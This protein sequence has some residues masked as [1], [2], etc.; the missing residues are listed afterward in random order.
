MLVYSERN[1]I[2]RKWH[3]FQYEFED[4]GAHLGFTQIF[5]PALLARSSVSRTFYR[6]SQSVSRRALT[7]VSLEQI[8]IVE[9]FDLFYAFFA[10]PSDIPHITH[11]KRWRERCGKAMCFIGEHYSAEAE[12]NRPYLQM[13]NELD[14]DR[15]F[16]FNTAPAESVASI[17]GCPVEFL[18]HGVDAYRWSP[19]PLV[20]ERSVDFYQFGRRS[21]TTHAAALD[22]VR[23]DGAFYIYDTIFNVPLEDH[24][25]HRS[26][27]AETMKRS[28]YFFAYR[29]GEDRGRA[30]Q[31]DPLSS[32]YFE[33]IGGGA[34]VLG[35][36]PGAKEYDD[37]FG[38]PDSTIEI[39]FEAHDLRDIVAALETD[40]VRLARARM[41]NIV[42]TL[43][44]LD[45]VY[46]WRRIFDAAGLPHTQAMGDRITDLERLAE[47]A[48]ERETAAL[49]RLG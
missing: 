46:R 30:Q 31:D 38:W 19:Y 48:E 7:E 11:L 37:C 36:R 13:L 10:F 49:E 14:F 32:R 39:P 45:W 20:P 44:T 4:V 24:Q 29:P 33:S 1:A 41:Q 16:V 3:A 42:Q 18:G 40:P 12:A 17:A 28:R 25:A 6:L 5:A 23:R 9:D 35:S 26:M 27:V 15:V 47:S 21:E 34:V 2:A 43:R 22:M 8:E